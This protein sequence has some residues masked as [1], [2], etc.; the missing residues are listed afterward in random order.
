MIARRVWAAL[1]AA[2]LLTLSSACASKPAPSGGSGLS[3]SGSKVLEGVV[4]E[5]NHDAPGSEGAS[6]QG[7][8]NY[9]LVIEARDGDA[10]AH[11]RYEVTSRQWHRVPEGS[12][13]RITLRNNFLQDIQPIN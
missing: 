5:R 1:L 10:T 9:Y 6:F 4:V 13:V 12:R 3:G 11:Y 2:V 8:G 7:T